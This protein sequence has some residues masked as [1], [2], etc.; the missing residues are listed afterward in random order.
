MAAH[1]VAYGPYSTAKVKGPD[2]LQRFPMFTPAVGNLA[3]ATEQAGRPDPRQ[4]EELRRV[5]GWV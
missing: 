1:P 4:L 2:D 5:V 3:E